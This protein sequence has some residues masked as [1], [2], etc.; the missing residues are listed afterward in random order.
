MG[1]AQI[2]EGPRVRVLGPRQLLRNRTFLLLQGRGTAS[3]VGYR[4]Y[5]GTIL[6]LSYKLTGGIYLAGVLI[7][8]QTAVFTLS[9]LVAPIVDGIQDK[10]RVY[11]S[12]YPLQAAAAVALGLAYLSGDLGIPLLLTIVVTLAILWDFTEAADVTTTRLLFGKQNLFAVSG[13]GSAIGGGVDVALYFTAGVAIALFGVAGGSYLLA[14]LMATGTVLALPLPIP[15]PNVVRQSW[16]PG[17]RK[18]WDL[19]RGATGKALRQLATLEFA[20][21]FFAAAPLLLLTLYVGRFFA[22]SQAE[23]AEFYVAYLV[24]GILAWLILGRTNPRGRIGPL[25]VA[26]IFLTGVLLVGAAIAVVSTL[27]SLLVWFAIGLAS[28][29]WS[30]L[31]WIYLQGRFNPEVLARVSMNIY[32]F[33]GVAGAIGAFTIGALSTSW[34]PQA[35]TILVAAGFIGASILGTVLREARTLTY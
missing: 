15:T 5:L 21:G 19:F 24:G 9:F 3:A 8:I 11:V 28:T 31:P 26:A 6:W 25:T 22:G 17:F 1:L 33:S 29:A 18:G 23:Y 2:P 7:G 14:G 27:W 12:C 35:L 32:L 20:S 10:R 34:T 30:Q 4:V 13:L 16:L